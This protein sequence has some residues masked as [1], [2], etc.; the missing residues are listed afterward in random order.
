[1]FTLL[2]ILGALVLANLGYVA[3]WWLQGYRGLSQWPEPHGRYYSEWLGLPGGRGE[4]YE[5]LSAQKQHREPWR[6]W[7]DKAKRPGL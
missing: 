1:M 2:S 5:W 4:Y 3:W 6:A 7:A